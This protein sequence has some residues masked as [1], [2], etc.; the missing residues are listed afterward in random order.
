MLQPIYTVIGPPSEMSSTEHADARALLAKHVTDADAW[1]FLWRDG[2]T[3]FFRNGRKMVSVS[4][5]RGLREYG[6]VFPS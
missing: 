5:C 4:L 3:Y 2:S 1:A 6:N